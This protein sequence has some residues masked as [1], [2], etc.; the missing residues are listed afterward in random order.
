[1]DISLREEVRLSVSVK[2]AGPVDHGL[3]SGFL[4][5]LA[6]EKSWQLPADLDR[7]DLITAKLINSDSWLFLLALEDEKPCGMAIMEFRFTPFDVRQSASIVAIVVSA[8]RRGKGIGTTLVRDALRHAEMRGCFEVDIAIDHDD[9]SANFFRRFGF[10]EE[11]LLLTRS[12][13]ADA[14]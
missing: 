5:D 12:I 14:E 9:Q 4:L 2:R 13:E 1:M 7:W 6:R 11:R 3:V 8:E 10:C